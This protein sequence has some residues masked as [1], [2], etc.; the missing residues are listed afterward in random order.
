MI[1]ELFGPP[2]VGKTTFAKALAERLRDRGH[3]VELV[4]SVRPAEGAPHVAPQVQRA[5]GSARSAAFERLRRPFLEMLRLLRRH[6]FASEEATSANDLVRMLTPTSRL[7]SFRLSQYLTRLSSSWQAAS[8]SDTIMVFDQ[9]F[10]QAVSSL[11]LLGE[12]EDEMLVS[13]LLDRA[14]KADLLIRLD[15]PRDVL[16][17][18][19]TARQNAQGLMERLFELDLARNLALIGIIDRLQALLEK[20]GETVIRVNSLDHQSHEEGMARVEERLAARTSAEPLRV[21]S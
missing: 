14:P 9:A 15:A 21:A 13:Q 4:M 20:R 8:A 6:S 7:W 3:A 11:M 17:A 10:I 5:S 2:G 16:E 19:L 12:N 18:R 1:I